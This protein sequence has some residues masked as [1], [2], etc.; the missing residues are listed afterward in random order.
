MFAY[1]TMTNMDDEPFS[2]LF[3]PANISCATVH[4]LDRPI[5]HPRAVQVPEHRGKSYACLGFTVFHDGVEQF[6]DR[7]FSLR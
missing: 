2:L 5:V 1:K 4:G 7:V 6:L 3:D